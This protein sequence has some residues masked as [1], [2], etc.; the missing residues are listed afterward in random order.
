MP[1]PLMCG[2]QGPK[3]FR[4]PH[5]GAGF[6]GFWRFPAILGVITAPTLR[7]DGSIVTAA[8]Y[9]PATKL[10]YQPD[11]SLRMPPFSND[12]TKNEAIKAVQLLLQ[13]LSDFPFRG[14]V[15]R[16]VALSGLISPAVRGALGRVPLHA[17]SAPC[18]G[19]GKSYLADLISTL[20]TGQVCPAMAAGKSEEE[21][22]KRL[23]GL[24]IA[25]FPIVSI[26]NV[27]IALGGDL[28]CQAVE[29]PTIRL[30]PLGGSDIV[31]IESLAPST[32]MGTTSSWK[33]T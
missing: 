11:P 9:D 3:I 17:A 20:V 4:V 22:E 1:T 13:P 23:G 25:G 31:E 5:V 15:D 2:T 32:R 33:A 6:A 14:P 19:T 30:R 8:G 10:I 18:P 16:A 21:L 7:R 26:D 12:P 28:L 27:S 29:R 24:F